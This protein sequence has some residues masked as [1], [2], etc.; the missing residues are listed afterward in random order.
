VSDDVAS[1]SEQ[2]ADVI[3]IADE[4]LT[5]DRRTVPVAATVDD[6]EAEALVGQ[7][8]LSWPRLRTGRQGPMDQDHTLAVPIVAV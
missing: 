7:R 2:P 5:C 1:S 3:G 4:V 6:H 8:Q